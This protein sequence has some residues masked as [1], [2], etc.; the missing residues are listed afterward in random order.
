MRFFFDE[1]FPKAAGSFICERGHEVID[2]RG[3]DQ[4]GADDAAIF[5]LAQEKA[6]VFLTTDRDFFHTVP[7]LVKNHQ[8]VVVVALR[9]PN[10]RRILE[11]LE[12]FLEH[13]EEID[14]SNKVFELRDHTYVV[15]P[16]LG[17]KQEPG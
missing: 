5:R 14:I 13:F 9:Q 3:T 10:R 6:A 2:I 8:G 16:M 7:L 17:E 12:W 1:N 15:H 4:E 11:R